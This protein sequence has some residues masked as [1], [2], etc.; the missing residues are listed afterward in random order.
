MILYYLDPFSNSIRAKKPLFL[1]RQCQAFKMPIRQV[2][3]GI[4]RETH[5][6]INI[7]RFVFSKKIVF[8]SFLYHTSTVCIDCLPILIKPGHHVE[9]ISCGRLRPIVFSMNGKN[10]YPLQNVWLLS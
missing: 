9:N 8:I 10:T 4:T 5:E 1:R 2:I 6:L 7:V 3:R